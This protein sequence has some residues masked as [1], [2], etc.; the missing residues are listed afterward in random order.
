MRLYGMDDTMIQIYS[1]RDIES[2]NVYDIVSPGFS[3][4]DIILSTLLIY[5]HGK[6][7]NLYSCDKYFD[8]FVILKLIKMN[9]LKHMYLI[10]CTKMCQIVS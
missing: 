3:K 8:T 10:N 1:I 9:L 5:N 7:I 2:I 4:L 6:A